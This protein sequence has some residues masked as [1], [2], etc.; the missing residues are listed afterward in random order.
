MPTK[1]TDCMIHSVKFKALLDTNVMH[2]LV[3]RDLLLW[4]AAYD[5]FTPKW[6]ENICEEWKR[7]ILRKG[8]SEEEANKR[9]AAP[10]KAF[11]DAMVQNYQSLVDKLE[12]PDAD[13]RHV[14]AAAIKSNAD[15]IVTQNLKDFPQEYLD[16]FGIKA[17]NADDF[18]TDII[19]LNPELAVQAFKEMVLNRKNPK[20]DE[21][22]VL[23]SLR[24]AGLNDTAN[25]L[26]AML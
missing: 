8:H 11:P 25:Y 18:L 17:K 19:D 10:N 24:R 7:V 12:L 13:D 1:K 4:L 20:M 3:I 9:I 23:E 5:L 15:V 26:H 21:Y 22:E 6:S 16:Q 2:P 14:L